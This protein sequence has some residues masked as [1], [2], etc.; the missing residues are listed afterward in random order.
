MYSRSVRYI[1]AKTHCRRRYIWQWAILKFNVISRYEI[2]QCDA[3]VAFLFVHAKY[4]TYICKILTKYSALWNILQKLERQ[5]NGI[6]IDLVSDSD[7]LVLKTIMPI[8]NFL[9]LMIWNQDSLSCLN[10]MVLKLRL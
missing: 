1:N 8:T 2:Q 4:L 3:K 10:L 6:L 5:R 9:F 7:T